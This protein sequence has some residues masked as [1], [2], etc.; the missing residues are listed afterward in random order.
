MNKDGYGKSRSTFRNLFTRVVPDKRRKI[1]EEI[2]EKESAE[3]AVYDSGKDSLKIIF[4]CT[5][6][7]ARSQMAEGFALDLK[8]KGYVDKNLVILSAGT[9]PKP[10]NPLSVKVMLEKGIDISGH[11]SKSLD[12]VD[13]DGA[14]YAVT[15]CGDAKGNCP[16]VS[17][18]TGNLHWELA[19]PAEAHGTE[20]EKLNVFRK[21]RDDIEVRVKELFGSFIKKP[22]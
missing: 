21:I 12:E 1:E 10:I 5:G 22:F 11:K 20:E 8:K 4:L 7:S 19:D 16:F 2:A 17:A 15:L 13:A 14:D 9:S 6:N 3:S 18:K